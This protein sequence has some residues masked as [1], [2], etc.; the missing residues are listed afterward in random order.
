MYA[1]LDMQHYIL[2]VMLYLLH[3]NILYTHDIQYTNILYIHDI[4]YTNI[5]Y[6]H[7]TQHD[8]IL[9]RIHMILYVSS[10]IFCDV[11][12]NRVAGTRSAAAPSQRTCGVMC[13]DHV[14]CVHYGAVCN[15]LML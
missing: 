3:T 6:I 5:L 15:G 9:Y 14:I 4:Q 8:D 12:C 1:N 2:Y 10:I 11:I 13:A 7:D